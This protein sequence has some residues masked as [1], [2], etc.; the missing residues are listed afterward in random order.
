MLTRSDYQTWKP[1]KAVIMA[2]WQNMPE[3][4]RVLFAQHR[5][6][7]RQRSDAEARKLFAPIY[8]DAIKRISQGEEIKLAECIKLESSSGT[9][10][11]RRHDGPTGNEAMSLLKKMMGMR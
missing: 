3:A 7:L 4:F 10:H 1:F 9:T 5:Y 8:Q 11:T 6:A 2:E